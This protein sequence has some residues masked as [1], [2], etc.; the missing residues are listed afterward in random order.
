MSVNIGRQQRGRIKDKNEG[1]G[2]E[3][4]AGL[5]RHVLLIS[6]LTATLHLKLLIPIQFRPFLMSPGDLQLL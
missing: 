1:D 5:V 2:S 4:A 3:S 6:C